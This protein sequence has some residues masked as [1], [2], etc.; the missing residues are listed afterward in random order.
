MKS[1]KSAMRRFLK[2]DASCTGFCLFVFICMFGDTPVY[3]DIYDI[4]MQ[5][6]RQYKIYSIVYAVFLYKKR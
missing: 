6:Y 2:E 5:F 4:D 3:I 1:S